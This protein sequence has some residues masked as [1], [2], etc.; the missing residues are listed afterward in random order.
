MVFTHFICPA[1]VSP[2]ICGIIDAPI[3]ESVRFNLIQIGQIIQMLALPRDEEIEQKYAELHSK[4][5]VSLITNLID[6]LLVSQSGEDVV[7]TILSQQSDFERSQMLS[8]H[9][10]ISYFTE[11]FRI[12]M[13]HDDYE[14][15]EQDRQKLNKVFKHIPENNIDASSSVANNNLNGN[16]EHTVEK[17]KQGF[18]RVGKVTKSKIAKSMSFNTNGIHSSSNGDGHLVNGNGANGSGTNIVGQGKSISYMVQ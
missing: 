15:P 5:E 13:A 8:T 12:L 17:A 10:E 3:S 1:I 9:T 16:S 4:F 2:D 11:F 6:L 18:I 14:I 7:A